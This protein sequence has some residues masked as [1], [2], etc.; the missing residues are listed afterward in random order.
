MVMRLKGRPPHPDW[1]V[2]Y[3]VECPDKS[4]AEL[5][6]REIND[7]ENYL[8]KIIHD[9][10]PPL[11]QGTGGIPRIRTVYENDFAT[12]YVCVREPNPDVED[13]VKRIYPGVW[14]PP[15]VS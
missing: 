5:P 13:D 1:P 9:E 14:V 10:P 3:P 6:T 8:L 11:V 2:K 7:V 4:K 15:Q 12:R